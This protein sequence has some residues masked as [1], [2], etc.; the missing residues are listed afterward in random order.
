M[1][2]DGGKLSGVLH[3]CSKSLHKLP[4]S[5]RI[6]PLLLHRTVLALVLSSG[7]GETKTARF[8][9]GRIDMEC[10]HSMECLHRVMGPEA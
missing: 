8:E 5:D 2:C 4:H 9:I 6:V 7:P 3:P 1:G 10:P